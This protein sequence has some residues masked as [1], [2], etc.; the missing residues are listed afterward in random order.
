[1]IGAY[2]STIIDHSEE[3]MEAFYDAVEKVID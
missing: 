1:V 2:E 3:E